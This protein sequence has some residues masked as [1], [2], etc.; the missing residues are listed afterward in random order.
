ML[1]LNGNAQSAEQSLS[2]GTWILSIAPGVVQEWLSHRKA[3]ITNT[4][5]SRQMNEILEIV[6]CALACPFVLPIVIKEKDQN[7]DT[8]DD[9]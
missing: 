4:Q 3:R 9:D 7:N 1:F 6:L 5:R 2:V 8:I